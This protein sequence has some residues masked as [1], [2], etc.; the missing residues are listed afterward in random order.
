M[1]VR[2]DLWIQ[3]LTLLGVIV[4]VVF[5]V[6]EEVRKSLL[7]ADYAQQRIDDAEAAAAARAEFELVQ[8]QTSLIQAAI[9]EVWER[10]ASARNGMRTQVEVRMRPS[11]EVVDVVILQSSGDQ[12]FD[13]SGEDAIYR[14]AP[15]RGLQSLP[16]DVLNYN[17][18]EMSFVFEPTD[19]LR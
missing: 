14:A 13:R 1:K 5:F 8:S 4:L 16:I 11:G 19:L 7:A 10:P 17:F 15:F 18:R 12:E 9:S 3:S 6:G 2:I